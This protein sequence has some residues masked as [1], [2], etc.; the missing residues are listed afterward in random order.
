MQAWRLHSYGGPETLT[1]DFVPAPTPSTTQALVSVSYA[2]INP[3]DWKVRE[4]YL[5]DFMPL[6]LPYTL[7]VDFVG[8]VKALGKDAGD[9]LKV[10]DRVMTMNQAMGAFADEIIV[11]A[12]ILAKVPKGLSDELAATIPKFWST[13]LINCFTMFR[14]V[15]EEDQAVLEHLQTI[16]LHRDAKDPRAVG[17]EFVFAPNEFFTNTTLR[18]DF[19][20][21]KDS[22]K[23]PHFEL[24]SDTT[25]KKV[26]IDWK[27]DE[28][29]QCKKR[30]TKGSIEDDF[31]PC[32]G[33]SPGASAKQWRSTWSC[34]T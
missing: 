12:D 19:E 5:K 9:R 7:G 15:D 11:E 21:T 22:D 1:L 34:M 30:P 32:G 33:R 6:P 3:F 25:T 10:G 31:E 23:L 29:N 4:G 17:I 8:I 2:G 18:K 28:V 16:K 27:S 26:A 14:Y 13:A 20:L 24:S